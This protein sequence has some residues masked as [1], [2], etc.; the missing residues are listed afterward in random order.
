MPRQL[1]RFA[2]IFIATCA[3]ISGAAGQKLPNSSDA[4]APW[5]SRAV[6]I[7]VGFPAG[8]SPDLTAR[9][10]PG[11]ALVLAGLLTTDA[12]AMR[13]LTAAHGFEETE[14]RT[15]NAW[16]AWA[17]RLTGRRADPSA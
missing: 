4:S 5:P 9:T 15:E 7:I 10:R 2:T 17:G 8:S 11:G 13:A 12:E 14:S 6:R 16:W 3:M 1:L